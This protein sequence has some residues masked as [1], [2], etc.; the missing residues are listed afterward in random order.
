MLKLKDVSIAIGDKIILTDV[1]FHIPKGETH[2]LF[3]PNGIGKSMLLKA[4]MGLPPAKVVKGEILY[5]GEDISN[6]SID[7]R[8]RKGIAMSFQSPPEIQGVKFGPFIKKLGKYSIDEEYKDHLKD[9]DLLRFTNRDLNAG[10]SGGELKRSELMQIRAQNPKL[11]MFDEPESGVDLEHI[12]M[13]GTIIK[14]ILR[15]DQLIRMPKDTSGL[16]VTHTGYILDYINAER[17]HIINNE[18]VICEGNPRDIF[19]HIEKFGFGRC[20]LCSHRESG[21]CYVD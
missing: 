14:R 1:N 20:E 3:G 12:K 8:A 16:I 11:I 2:V 18:G 9:L 15:K 17:G 10:F 6:L 13:V 4:I 7:E 21:A 19:Q 5:C